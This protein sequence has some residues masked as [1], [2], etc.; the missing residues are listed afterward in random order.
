MMRKLL[1]VIVDEFTGLQIRLLL[2]RF[3]L[4]F[5]PNSVGVRF[6]ALVL[7]IIGLHIGKGTVFMGTPIFIGGRKIYENLSIGN[8]CFFSI[9]T[10]FDLAGPITLEDHVTLGPDVMLITG[11]HDIGMRER[12][13]GPLSPKPIV[14]RKGA[15]LG[16]RCLVLP[17]ITIGEGAV[18]G[19]G[20]VVTKDV[21]EGA[22]VGGIP[23][24]EIRR[25]EK[26]LP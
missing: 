2:A 11:A 3:I 9:G 4:L 17:G 21:P 15:W 19:A 18:I 25:L 22:V 6:R 8:M 10:F 1:N 20:A 12:R 16:A 26:L 24:K 23:A 13:A 14:I 7:R 5:V